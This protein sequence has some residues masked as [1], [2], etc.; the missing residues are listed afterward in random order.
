MYTLTVNTIPV[1]NNQICMW[2]FN[3]L[4]HRAIES[5]S[6][7]WETTVSR[8]DKHHDVIVHKIPAPLMQSIAPSFTEVHNFL[9]KNL[10]LSLVFITWQQSEAA[11]NLEPWGKCSVRWSRVQTAVVLCSMRHKGGTN[12]L[13][14]VPP[15]F[16]NT[17]GNSSRNCICVILSHCRKNNQDKV[18][19]IVRG[20]KANRM[21]YQELLW[22]TAHWQNKLLFPNFLGKLRNRKIQGHHC[23]TSYRSWSC[24]KIT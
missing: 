2:Q 11:G 10:H 6:I 18:E 15:V 23:L 1:P 5:I 16:F 12:Q 9:E 17:S 22:N 7:I 3:M 14:P 13:M 24:R 8:A 19:T 21:P 4:I 20:V